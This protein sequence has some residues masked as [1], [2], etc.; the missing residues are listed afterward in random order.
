MKEDLQIFGHSCEFMFVF[1]IPSSPFSEYCLFV[2]PATVTV[3]KDKQV[4]PGGYLCGKNSGPGGGFLFLLGVVS[5]L[6]SLKMGSLE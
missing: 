2:Q 5:H 1:E 3:E 6:G 4:Q